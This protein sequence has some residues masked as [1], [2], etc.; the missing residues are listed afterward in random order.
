MKARR[1]FFA[2]LK[3]EIGR[4]KVRVIEGKSTDVA[5]SL[6]IEFG[7]MFDMVFIDAD[8]SYEGCRD[9]IAA[10]R[11]LLKPGGLFCGHDYPWPS[12]AV[13]WKGVGRAVREAFGVPKEGP[14]SIWWV[15]VQT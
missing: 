5:A 12:V 2:N 15:N 13:P 11:P 14:S 7:Q 3:A 10:Y 4:G 1:D 8:H 6:L 9:D